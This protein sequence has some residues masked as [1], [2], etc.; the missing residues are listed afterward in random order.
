MRLARAL[1][2]P[3]G[4]ERGGR[5]ALHAEDV[6]LRVVAALDGVG[7]GDGALVHL[8]RVHDE[9]RGGHHALV[10]G[11]AAQVLLLLVVH[12]LVLRPEIPLAVVAEDA[13]VGAAALLAAHRRWSGMVATTAAAVAAAAV[14]S[15]SE[16]AVFGGNCLPLVCRR[17]HGVSQ[18]SATF[19]P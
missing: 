3:C 18:W 2:G 12:Q 11:R 6:D 13:R 10:A 19:S 7:D 16:S 8:L 4:L 15:E 14:E 5:H 9:P 1:V 17:E